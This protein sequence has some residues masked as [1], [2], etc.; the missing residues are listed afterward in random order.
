VVG[1][2]QY[3]GKILTS[4]SDECECQCSYVCFHSNWFA[5][6]VSSKV[7]QSTTDMW[8]MI[9]YEK[10]K[11]EEWHKN[12]CLYGQC[13]SYGV[14]KFP[15]CLKESNGSIEALVEWKRFAME[16]TTSR[17]SKSL[18]IMDEYSSSKD[19]SEDFY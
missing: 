12:K 3:E 13:I 8:Q 19:N 2:E 4:L 5:C 10:L 16:I 1:L 6:G 11:E 15:F 17:A 9:V 18:K 14:D 7:Y